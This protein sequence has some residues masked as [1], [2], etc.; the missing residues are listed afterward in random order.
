M[1][2]S[3]SLWKY[4]VKHCFVVFKTSFYGGESTALSMTIHRL[5]SDKGKGFRNIADFYCYA[6]EQPT[7]LLG[8]PALLGAGMFLLFL[9]GTLCR[10]SLALSGPPA[11]ARSLRGRDAAVQRRGAG[12]ALHSVEASAQL[13]DVPRQ[14]SADG[15]ILCLVG[16]LSFPAQFL[17]LVSVKLLLD[18]PHPFQL[19]YKG[20]R[21]LLITWLTELVIVSQS[22]SNRFYKDLLAAYRRTRQLEETA[23]RARYMALQTQ[24]N[25][26][27]LFNSLNTL[28]A[29]IEYNPQGAV[30]FTRNLSDVYR[31]ILACQDKRLV[32]LREEMEFVDTYVELHRVRLG[33]CLTVDWQVDEAV[34]EDAQLPPLTLQVLVENIVKHNVISPSRPMAVEVEVASDEEGS[35]WLR[36]SN[37]LRPKL[38]AVSGGHGL[39]NLTQRYRLLCGKEI[40]VQKGEDCFT[41]KVPLLYE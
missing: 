5:V 22:V 12:H 35:P 8:H 21:L 25:P 11:H 41:V 15:T 9:P 3:V 40:C 4:S 36:M 1:I 14:P 18:M 39:D 37:P 28:V 13:S 17:L 20:T 34:R 16:R 24:L 26:H 7:I 10:Y 19:V 33:D 29:E 32:G 38:G 31:Y 2:N 27:F 23:L 30:S 6:T